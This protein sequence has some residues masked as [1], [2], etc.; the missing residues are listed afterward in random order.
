M[1]VGIVPSALRVTP[2]VVQ[3]TRVSIKIA[4]SLPYAPNRLSLRNSGSVSALPR[5][6]A[7][8]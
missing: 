1:V 5:L 7:V 8:W 6:P 2:T 4:V 3:E